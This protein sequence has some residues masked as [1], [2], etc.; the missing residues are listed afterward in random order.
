MIKK[1]NTIKAQIQL[2]NWAD[3]QESFKQLNCSANEF[4]KYLDGEPEH[5]A[6]DFALLGFYSKEF[7][8]KKGK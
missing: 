4:K 5:V 6:R 8:A 2:G 3:A 7:K 1:L